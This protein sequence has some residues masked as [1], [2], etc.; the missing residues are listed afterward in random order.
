MAERLRP[1]RRAGRSLFATMRHR[2]LSGRTPLPEAKVHMM[3]QRRALAAGIRTK[4]SLP[5]LPRTGIT[6]YLQNGGNIAV[7]QQM[8]GHE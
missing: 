2:K 1:G 3:I 7:A 5:Q 8:A 4:I 6:R